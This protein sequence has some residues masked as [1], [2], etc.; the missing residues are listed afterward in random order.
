MWIL[1]ILLYYGRVELKI[2]DYRFVVVLIDI[3]I[4]EV[5]VEE[6]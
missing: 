4:F 1:G 5:E 2:F 6:R 3:D